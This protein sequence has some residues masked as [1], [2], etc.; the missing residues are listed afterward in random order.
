MA[1]KANSQNIKQ[2]VSLTPQVLGS[3]LVQGSI[4]GSERRKNVWRGKSG[5]FFE[6]SPGSPHLCFGRWVRWYLLREN[7]KC[8]LCSGG[9]LPEP[10]RARFR[11]GYDS[12]GNLAG[13][14]SLI[15]DLG[16]RARK[17]AVL[18][19]HNPGLL[20]QGYVK[21]PS[22]SYVAMPWKTGPGSYPVGSLGGREGPTDRDW[23]KSPEWSPAGH[24]IL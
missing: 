6:R 10:Q 9:N 22:R 19:L 23:G 18:I 17:G 16:G 15:H 4:K 1:I 13:M 5:D 14:T 11:L 24:R 8:L 7:L 20:G 21:F 2:H 12:L 3:L